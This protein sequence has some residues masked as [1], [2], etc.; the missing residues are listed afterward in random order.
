MNKSHGKLLKTSVIYA[1]GQ[2]A[3]QVLNFLLLPIYTNKLGAGDYGK[4]ATITAFT[5]FISTFLII[6]IY[7]GFYRFYKECAGNIDEENKM[8]NTALNFAYLMSCFVVI[9]LIIIG[10]PISQLIFNFDNGHKILWIII[11]TSIIS[12]IS[13]IYTSKYNLEYKALKVSTINIVKLSIQFITIIFLVVYKNM[14]II[15]ILYGQLIANSIIYLYLFI[16]EHKNYKTEISLIMLKNMLI[17]SGGLLPVNVSGWILQLSDRY[18]LS[19]YK[20]FETV[21][22]YNLGY[23]FG[24]LINPIFIIPFMGSF[25]PYAL[26]TYK[27]DNAKESLKLLMRNYNVIGCFMMIGISIFTKTGI[28]LFAN[29]NFLSAYSIVP[30]VVYS[31]FLYGK[32]F[33]YALGLQIKNKTYLEGIYMILSAGINIGLNFILVPRMGMMGAAIS[34][35]VSYLILNVIL[36][37]SSQKEY[38]INLDLRFTIGV[39]VLTLLFYLI[40]LTY[41]S[42]I[43]NIYSEVLCNIGL[44]GAYMVVLFKFKFIEFNSIM[45]KIK[46]IRKR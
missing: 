15:G 19:N 42:F 7:S 14:G 6:S 30:M 4:Y 26:E 21:G 38:K 13:C 45:C 44:I 40:Y 17:F 34:T 32:V 16:I 8:I 27:N 39:Q 43:Y 36:I 35:V 24:M 5:G 29:K 22:I 46:N 12:Q 1:I 28:Y 2:V 3:S 20:G 23:Q 41:S 37:C 10:K 25:T 18:F 9:L 33:Y 11:I 31:Y